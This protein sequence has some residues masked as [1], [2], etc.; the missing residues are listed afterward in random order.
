MTQR[1]DAATSRGYVQDPADRPYEREL[2]AVAGGLGDAIR[3][4]R[5]RRHLTLAQLAEA[6]SL[7]D[8]AIHAVESGRVASLGTYVK[9]ARALRLKPEFDLVDPRRRGALKAEDPVHAAMGEAQ[10]AQLRSLGFE[11]RIDE[12][13]QHYQ[14]AGRGDVVAWSVKGADLLHIE[15]RTAFPNIQ[16]AFGAFNAKREYLGEQLAARAGVMRWRSESHVMAALWSSDVLRT[17]KCHEA[18]FASLGS[19]GATI[20]E[21]WWRGEPPINGKGGGLVIFDPIQSRRSD[22]RPLADP[23]DLATARPRCRGYA[24]ALAALKDAGRA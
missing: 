4:E 18:S 1:G 7:S 10:A 12:P 20:L 24:E 22:R 6:A 16:E 2:G 5:R 23:A 14:F 9:L 17:I 13:F 3:A 8:S 11:V 15:N 19:Q 21:A